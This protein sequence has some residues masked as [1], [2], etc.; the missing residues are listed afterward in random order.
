[1]RILAF[2]LL[3]LSWVLALYWV[4]QL[5]AIIPTHFDWTGTPDDFGSRWTI[6]LLPA[7]TSGVHLLLS[8]VQRYPGTYNYPVKV[9]AQ[10]QAQLQQLG[11]QLLQILQVSI[12][13]M[14]LLLL[15]FIYS[16]VKSGAGSLPG[17]LLPVV[18]ALILGPVFYYTY[19]MSTVKG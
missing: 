4:Q 11:A 16:T 8:I 19:K 7:I 9:T 2:T 12:Q 10:N 3:A 13:V 6:V 17:W 18:L 14:T 1:M 5:P 15:Y